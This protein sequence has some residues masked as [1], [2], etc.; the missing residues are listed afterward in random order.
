MSNENGNM[1]ELPATGKPK[2]EHHVEGA[3]FLRGV[4]VYGH[5]DGAWSLE[6]MSAKLTYFESQE[7]LQS[8]DSKT[9]K[10]WM[11]RDDAIAFAEGIMK[12]AG[13]TDS[14]RGPQPCPSDK[15]VH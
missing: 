2:L 3:Y 15:I 5:V 13:R 12:E 10:L 11:F 9:L 7:K 6:T 1:S 8:G 14:A 4:D